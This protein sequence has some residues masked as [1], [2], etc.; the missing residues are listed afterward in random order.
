L[1]GAI[2]KIYKRGLVDVIFKQPYCRI[3]DV[4][5]AG[6]A[7]R[8]AAARYVKAMVEVGDLQEQ[9]AGREKLFLHPKLMTLLTRGGKA[10]PPHQPG[11]L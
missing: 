3:T 7:K 5:N 6:M 4:V 2:P 1:S 8:Q 10:F 11:G 9:A